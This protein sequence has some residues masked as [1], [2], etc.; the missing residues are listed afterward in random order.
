MASRRDELNAYSFARKRTNAAF[1]KPLPNGSIES[2]PKPLKA[3]MPSIMVALLILVGFGACGILKPVAPQGWDAVRTNV[4]VGSES[5]TRYVVLKNKNGQKLLHPILNLASAKLLL[6]PDKFKV[7]SVKEAELDGKLPHGAA[8]GIPYAPDRLPSTDDV[9]KPKVWAV[10]NRPGS[11]GNTNSKPQQAVF[12]LGDKDKSKVDGQGKLDLD[13]ALYVEDEND[14]KWLVD[15]NGIAFK[16]D[17]TL[18]E[19][20]N[21]RFKQPGVDPVQANSTLRR[22]IF[23]EA[24]PQKVTQDWMDTLIKSPLPIYMPTIEGVGQPGS[25]KGVPEKYNKVGT[26]V[27]DGSSGQKYVVLPQGVQQVSNFVAKLLLQ[28]PTGQKLNG[29]DSVIAPKVASGSLDPMP[30][31]QDPDKT[32][33]YLGNIPFGSYTDIEMPWPTE[34]VDA[35]NN[36]KSGSMTGG[37]TSPTPNGVSCSVYTGTS[38]KYPGDAGKALGF[39]NGVPNMQTWVGKDYPAKIAAGSNSYVTPGSGLLFNQVN[40]GAQKAGDGSLFLVTDTGLRYSVPKGNDSN[41]HTGK[42]DQE[43]DQAQI[44]LGYKGAHPPLIL[45][46]WSSLLSAGPNLAVSD[47]EKPQSS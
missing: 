33:K 27:E 10:C 22:I 17:A 30:D 26:V 38:T 44:H 15:S 28:G 11:S 25:G 31:S 16:F 39:P 42:G 45:K 24:V 37:L 43:V 9:D 32:A 7:V 46:A 18:A 23:G 47:A 5:T 13:Q 3:V 34:A 1:L 12:V 8:V 6:D 35:A 36:F 21:G 20:A 29:G 14:E 40:T 2:A 41:T 19:F 4:L